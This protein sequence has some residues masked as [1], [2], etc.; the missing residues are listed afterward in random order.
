MKKIV[1]FLLLLCTFIS[2]QKDNI[3][4][5]EPLLD[6]QAERDKYNIDISSLEK[7]TITSPSISM[8]RVPG[9][10][11]SFLLSGEEV[12][13]AAK[14]FWFA[15]EYIN[16][17]NWN[18]IKNWAI[19]NLDYRF[20]RDEDAGTDS[21]G[22]N[23]SLSTDPVTFISWID[24]LLYCNGFTEYQNS[25]N[26]KSYSIVYYIDEELTKPLTSCFDVSDEKYG[27]GI[28]IDFE[29]NGFRI[30]TVYEWKLAERIKFTNN[31]IPKD[32]DPDLN[33]DIQSTEGAISVYYW[34]WDRFSLE[35]EMGRELSED[36]VNVLK[37]YDALG[38]E[39]KMDMHHH[40]D[41]QYGSYPERSRSWSSNFYF[42]ELEYIR[43]HHP[44][45]T[46]YCAA[47]YLAKSL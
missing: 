39:W 8:T 3:I 27:T 30:P 7:S 26:G 41:T 13:T 40:G 21:R 16:F 38:D 4:I 29:A 5:P 23:E 35:K 34:Y 17:E 25:I 45:I 31:W 42:Q 46:H 32:I 9:G 43:H 10:D 20:M 37:T 22:M 19:E 2:C 47:L 33:K 12:T 18:L 36:R 11:V 1:L 14:E 44:G 28:Y 15:D 24:A 6:V